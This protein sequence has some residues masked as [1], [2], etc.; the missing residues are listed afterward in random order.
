[1]KEIKDLNKWYDIPVYT[2]KDLVLRWQWPP[3]VVYRFNPIP[4]K[5]PAGFLCRNWKAD[6]K[7]DIQT[8]GTQN[9][10]NILG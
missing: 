9:I 4:V 7:V 8:Q 2:L 5:I 3:K 6:P 10:Q 1:M